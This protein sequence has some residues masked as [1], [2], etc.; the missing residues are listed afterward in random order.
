MYGTTIL[1]TLLHL[2]VLCCLLLAVLVHTL[3]GLPFP[4]ETAVLIK[5]YLSKRLLLTNCC[6]LFHFEQ[7]GLCVQETIE[8][9]HINQEF[10][11]CS[12]ESEVALLVRSRH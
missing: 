3:T 1:C 4:Q 7:Y 9:H 5:V 11:T 10:A 6:N 8:H 2:S 12:K